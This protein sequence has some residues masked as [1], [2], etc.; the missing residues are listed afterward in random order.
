MAW[1]CGA[2][3]SGLKECL[4][5]APSLALPNAETIIMV[6]IITIIIMLVI[7]IIIITIIMVLSK[8]LCSMSECLYQ[9][10]IAILTGICKCLPQ[11]FAPIMPNEIGC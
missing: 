7:M 8:L 10:I 5:L 2:G 6:I 11:Y 1:F 9:K 4:S 3:I